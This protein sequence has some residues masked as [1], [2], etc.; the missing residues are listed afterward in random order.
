M[1]HKSFESVIWAK[2]RLHLKMLLLSSIALGR[3][4]YWDKKPLILEN[5]LRL[6]YLHTKYNHTKIQ[7]LDLNNYQCWY[8]SEA[9]RHPCIHPSSFALNQTITSKVL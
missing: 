1:G 2:I 4:S 5:Y 9:F 3:I 8:L 7:N 6:L